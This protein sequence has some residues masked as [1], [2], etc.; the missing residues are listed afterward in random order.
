M[1]ISLICSVVLWTTL[2]CCVQKC[3]I[4]WCS[5]HYFSHSMQ[6]CLM[7]C[8][9]W[10]VSKRL[11]STRWGSCLGGV[12]LSRFLSVWKHEKRKIWKNAQVTHS[13]FRLFQN[14]AWMMLECRWSVFEKQSWNSLHPQCKIHPFWSSSVVNT[15]VVNSVR[16]LQF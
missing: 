3:L 7:I 6:T 8:S 10:T 13:K 11:N 16:K 5:L 14:I 4:D 2:F 9:D 1:S 12:W 15:G